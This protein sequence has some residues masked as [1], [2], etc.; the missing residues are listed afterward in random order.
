MENYGI[1]YSTMRTIYSYFGDKMTLDGRYS[2]LRRARAGVMNIVR[3]SIGVTKIA[4]LMVP[5]LKGKLNGITSFV[6]IP[7]E[8]ILGFVVMTAKKTY[9]DTMNAALKTSVEGP[10]T[11]VL[12][13]I[14]EPFV[15][16]DFKRTHASS[17]V[18]G[19]Q[20]MVM[21]GDMVEVVLKYDYKCEG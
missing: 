18:E 3:I 9:K 4:A 10:L 6:P 17:A 19:K 7:N 2:H 8:F 15:S 11:N 16:F 21:G 20:S 12:A 13:Y 14:E 5:Q 1:D